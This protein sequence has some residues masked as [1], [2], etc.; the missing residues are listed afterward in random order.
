MG[1]RGESVFFKYKKSFLS[2]LGVASF[3][4]LLGPITAPIRANAL[5]FD[6]QGEFNDYLTFPH[7]D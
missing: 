3:V 6:A 2:V 1:P 5:A 4:V 7:I